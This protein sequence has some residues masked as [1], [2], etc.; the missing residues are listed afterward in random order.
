MMNANTIKNL[1]ETKICVGCNRTMHIAQYTNPQNI[2][3]YTGW[4]K[5]LYCSANCEEA[6]VKRTRPKKYKNRK[7]ECAEQEIEIKKLIPNYD[8]ES[9]EYHIV[10]LRK[11]IRIKEKRKQRV[12][13]ITIPR[14]VQRRFDEIYTRINNEL[15]EIKTRDS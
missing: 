6:Y 14:I 7:M 15:I 9:K 10:L 11:N 4:K 1:E 13:V 2:Y 8:E 12:L 5:R 3:T